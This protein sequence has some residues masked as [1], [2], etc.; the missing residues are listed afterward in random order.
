MDSL[1]PNVETSF[2][3]G[4]APGVNPLDS[5]DHKGDCVLRRE[6]PANCPELVGRKILALIHYNYIVTYW[7][8][9]SCHRHR[10]VVPV[11]YALLS[12]PGLVRVNHF[13]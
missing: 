2:S 12:H 5:V 6:M 8:D 9:I 3:P 10:N 11:E 1:G 13:V 4:K 7:L